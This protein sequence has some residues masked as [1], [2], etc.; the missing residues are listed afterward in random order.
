MER[1]TAI[2]Q[3]SKVGVEPRSTYRVT[4]APAPPPGPMNSVSIFCF[5][6]FLSMEKEKTKARRQGLRRPECF[7]FPEDCSA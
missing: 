5:C 6:L 1:A 3:S 7:S 4:A 2:K